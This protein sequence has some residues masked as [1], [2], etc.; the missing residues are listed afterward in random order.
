ME[1]YNG[2]YCVYAHVNKINGKMYVGQTIYGGNPNKRWENGRGYKCN[3]HFWSAIQKYGWDNFEH[4]IIANNLTASEADNFERLLI[5]KL[6]LMNPDK[7]YNLE[8]GG[9]KN[10][11]LSDVVKRQMSK[12]HIGIAAGEN[13]PFYGKKHSEESRKKMSVAQS[14]RCSGP[15]ERAKRSEISKKQFLSADAREFM[16]ILKSKSVLCIETGKIYSSALEAKR[17]T[18]ANNASISNCCLHKPYYVTAGGYHWAYVY[19]TKT[20]DGT[21]IPGAISLGYITSKEVDNIEG[22]II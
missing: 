19:D 8:S 12:S 17:L 2:T 6:D 3:A 13:N 22:F 4:E 7:G 10:K 5:T 21:I 15:E 1:I 20:K 16:S 11:I 18:G 14:K 9:S